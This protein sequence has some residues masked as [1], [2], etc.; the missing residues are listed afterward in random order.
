MKGRRRLCVCLGGWEARAEKVMSSFNII[1]H[2]TGTY[3]TVEGASR[4][5]QCS[6]CPEGEF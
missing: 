4:P 1:Y 2:Y 5:T 6:F 3:S